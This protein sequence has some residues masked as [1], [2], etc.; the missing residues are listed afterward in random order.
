M[1]VFFSNDM[2]LSFK[3]CRTSTWQVKGKKL[4]GK[5]CSSGI[6]PQLFNEVAMK[7]EII[8]LAV[9]TLQK[10]QKAMPN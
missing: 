8:K 5:K 9:C 3:K 1:N 4:M 7:L 2:L 10:K 6:L